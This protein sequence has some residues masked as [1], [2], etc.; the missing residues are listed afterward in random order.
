MTRLFRPAPDDWVSQQLQG[1]ARFAPDERRSRADRRR[2]VWWA[3]FYGSFNPRRRRPPRRGDDSRYHS[4]DWHGAHL[5]AVSIGILILNVADA[6]LTLRLIS[7]GAIEI[8][9]VMDALVS[10]NVAAFATL[11]MGMTGISVVTMVFLARYRFMRAVR[12]EMVL[13]GVLF[14]YTVLIGYEFSMLQG[15]AD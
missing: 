7:L 14:A 13:Y 15:F 5:L 2:R 8:N 12:V 10:R 6:F 9:P 3:V 11:K 1:R 4:L